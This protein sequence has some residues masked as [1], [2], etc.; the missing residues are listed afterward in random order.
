MSRQ[1]C[2]H[3]KETKD[4]KLINSKIVR[5]QRFSWEPSTLGICSLKWNAFPCVFICI[6]C[7]VFILIRQDA[8]WSLRSSHLPVCGSV[9]QNEL[10]LEVLLSPFV[11]C[12]FISRLLLG[13][14]TGTIPI[15]TV[16]DE[17]QGELKFLVKTTMHALIS[18]PMDDELI[19]LLHLHAST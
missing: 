12:Y 18:R 13:Y 17:W 8:F 16:S 1:H 14:A 3:R 2:L 4:N 10:L 6:F 15:C 19:E 11:G 5:N 9:C 7:V